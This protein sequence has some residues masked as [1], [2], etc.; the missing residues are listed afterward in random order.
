MKVSKCTDSSK[1]PS[2]TKEY[3]RSE[4]FSTAPEGVY[5]E[6]DTSTTNIRMVVCGKDIIYRTVL[7]VDSTGTS[8]EG[9]NKTVDDKYGPTYIFTDESVCFEIRK[10]S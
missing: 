4:L 7:Y 9:L 5:K 10:K 8:I 2:Y 6:T 1:T 3:S